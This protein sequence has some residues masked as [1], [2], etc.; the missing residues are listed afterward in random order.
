MIFS[1]FGPQWECLQGSY[2][3]WLCALVCFGLIF[4]FL[5]LTACESAD[6][7]ADLANV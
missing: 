5:F 7:L 4:F 1:L 2:R 6:G 3:L